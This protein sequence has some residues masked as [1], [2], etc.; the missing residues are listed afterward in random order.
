MASAKQSLAL[1]AILAVSVA[2]GYL[3]YSASQGTRTATVAPAAIDSM[4]VDREAISAM[5][6][7]APTGTT[8]SLSEWDG[9]PQI[10]NFWATWCGPCREEMPVLVKAQNDYADKGL[11]VIGLSMDYPEDTELVNRFAEEYEVEFP[12]LM[13]VE[14]GNQLARFYGADNFV[15]PISIFVKADGTVANIHTGLLTAEQAEEQL[16]KLF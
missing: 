3:T 8:H 1:F 10:V 9:R 13:A 14:Q 4:A 2:A 7:N 16:S 11:V 5:R 12:L 6:L 15:L